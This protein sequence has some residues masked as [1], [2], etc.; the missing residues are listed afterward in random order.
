[1]KT[2]ENGILPEETLENVTGGQKLIKPDLQALNA[3]EQCNRH[4]SAIS[5][6]T[7]QIATGKT[8]NRAEDDPASWAI[9]KRMEEQMHRQEQVKN[10]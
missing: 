7:E 2:E 4:E 5:K 8:I 1:M 10:P 3:L 6:L 9:A